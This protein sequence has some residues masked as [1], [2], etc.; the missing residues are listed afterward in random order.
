MLGVVS[1]KKTVKKKP[2]RNDLTAYFIKSKRKEKKNLWSDVISFD[3]E[4]LNLF[5]KDK[6]KMGNVLVTFILIKD[7]PEAVLQ[8]ML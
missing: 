7:L 2:N 3:R 5:G 1:Q 4:I 6:K 8:K